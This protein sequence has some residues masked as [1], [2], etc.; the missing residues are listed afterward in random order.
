MEKVWDTRV[1]LV[2]GVGGGRTW[3]GWAVSFS[4]INFSS[5]ESL[6]PSRSL[7]RFESLLFLCLSQLSPAVFDSVSLE[8]SACLSTRQQKSRGSWSGRQ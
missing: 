3:L 4:V 5:Q 2:S 6:L 8:L 1:P 7:P